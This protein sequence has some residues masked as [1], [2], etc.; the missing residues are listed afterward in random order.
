[1]SEMWAAER[2]AFEALLDDPDPR[3]V[4]VGKSGVEFARERQRH[5]VRIERYN[6][7]HGV[8]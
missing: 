7:V 4:H 3:L 6:A 1:M 5:A 8:G 2:L